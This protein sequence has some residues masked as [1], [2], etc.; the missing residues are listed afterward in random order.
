[1]GSTAPVS[2]ASETGE[3]GCGPSWRP[4][5]PRCSAVTP[6]KPARPA[7]AWMGSQTGGA[8]LILTV[9]TPHTCR[10]PVL[11]GKQTGEEGACPCGDSKRLGHFRTQPRLRRRFCCD[12]GRTAS[13]RKRS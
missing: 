7:R 2:V 13:Q 3:T 8:V 4:D 11:T 12:L 5:A 6:G 10:A 9:Y 1:M